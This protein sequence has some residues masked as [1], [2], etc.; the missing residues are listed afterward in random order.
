VGADGV[1]RVMPDGSVDL[2]WSDHGE[3][4]IAGPD[5]GPVR[6]DLHAG[7]LIAGLRFRPGAAGAALGMPASDLRDTRV[8]LDAL[9]GRRGDELAERLASAADKRQALEEELLRRLPELQMPN[10][11]IAEAIRRLGRP[12]TRVGS[13]SATLHVSERQLRRLFH[14]SVGYGPKTLDRV[15]RFQR[16]LSLRRSEDGLAGL[17]AELGYADQAHLTREARRLSGLSPTALLD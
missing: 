10:G 6:R 7:S 16:F 17:A 15:L 9:W 14:D 12:G 5:T 4:F 11:L 2:V 3:L 8:P 13:L 1:G